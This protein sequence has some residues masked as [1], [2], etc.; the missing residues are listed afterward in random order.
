M[1]RPTDYTHDWF[2]ASDASI[3]AIRAAAARCATA[4]GCPVRIHRHAYRDDCSTGRHELAG[5]V[6]QLLLEGF[7]LPPEVRRARL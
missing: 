4:D 7:V 3:D 5:T 2:C 6:T 1:P